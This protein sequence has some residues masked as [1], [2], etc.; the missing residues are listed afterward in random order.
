MQGDGVLEEQ[1]GHWR[2]ERVLAQ[3][4]VLSEELVHL[5]LA[6]DEQ[7]VQLAQFDALSGK[8]LIDLMDQ[9]VALDEQEEHIVA[10]QTD[11]VASIERLRA[12][13]QEAARLVQTTG[14]T[15]TEVSPKVSDTMSAAVLDFDTVADATGAR[16]KVLAMTSKAPSGMRVIGCSGTQ[17]VAPNVEAG[18]NLLGV[19]LFLFFVLMP[20]PTQREYG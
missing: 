1:D 20:M 14:A 13:A 10:M 7:D 3:C 15:E 8:L 5:S 6:I 16:H 9:Q 2:A 11:H 18:I 4:D 17:L 19:A 12:E